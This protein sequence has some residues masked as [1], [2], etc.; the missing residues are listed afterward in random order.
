MDLTPE[1]HVA[2]LRC[3][4]DDVLDGPTTRDW[5]ESNAEAVTELQ[6]QRMLQEQEEKRQVCS[7][8]RGSV[9]RTF[10]WEVC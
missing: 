5:L 3:L 2:L 10:W 7:T 6:K 8:F 1:Q 4:C 9:F